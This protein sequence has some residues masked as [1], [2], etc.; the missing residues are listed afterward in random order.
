MSVASFTRLSSSNTYDN[1]VRN[2]QTRQTSL[3][4]LQ[5]EL[6]SGKK[7]TSPSDDPTGAAQAERAM[8]RIA[9][10]AADQRALEAQKS[11]ITAA[12]GALGDISTALQ[13]FRELTV[14]AGNGIN[15]AADRQTIALQLSGLKDQILSIANK[16]D[17]N[18][19]P[20]FAALGSALAPFVGPQSSAPD[21]TFNGLPGQAT[22]TETAI[23]ATLDGNAA[24]M[25]QPTKDGVYNVTTTNTV[26][27]NIPNG[28]TLQT[29][30]VTV[31]NSTLVNGSAYTINV[32][33]V[34]TT[35]VPGQTT[36]TY[37]V[38]ENPNVGGPYLGQSGSFPTTQTN[39]VLTVTAMPGL[40]LKI[41]GTPAVN[42][43]ITVTPAPS[44]F[45]TLDSAIKDIGTA[46]NANAATQAVNQALT[47]LDIG[48]AKVS[49]VRG[50]AGD[51]LNRADRITSNNDNKTIQQQS[52]RSRAED[53][54][55]ITAISA[56]QNQQTG[57]SAALQSYAQVQKLSLFN[58]IG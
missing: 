56:F 10:I 9:R 13:S 18:G 43:Q 20:L 17:S 58:F 50:R 23:P 34:D 3:A 19:Q 4:N 46:A 29:D 26:A 5:E 54:D 32:T 33:G 37:D 2:L 24:F 40:S 14:S 47:N 12:E 51:L 55:M 30:G 48:M 45:S 21:Y 27:G 22:S 6:T 16:S 35:T 7:I 25:Q 15:T 53:V 39:G 36:V 28:R 49:A 11:S 41:N 42:D 57:Y 52:D 31:T 44:L 1:A 38:L 8:T